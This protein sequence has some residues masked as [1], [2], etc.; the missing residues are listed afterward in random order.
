MVT[1]AE[2]AAAAPQLA[3]DGHELLYARGDGEALLATVREGE[4]PRIHPINVAVVE[5][6]LYAFLLPSA[7]R[8]DLEVDG[9]FALHSH[10]DP[11]A[12]SEFEVR[13]RARI[14][15]EPLRS[16]IAAG[17]Y[18]AIDDSY[19]LFQLMIASALLGRRPTADDWP[20]QYTSWRPAGMG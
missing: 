8:R 13:G 19:E 17:W 7:K 6:G 3:A 1:W 2:F 9:R 4:P 20:P 18:F 5:G 12:P 10:Q 15:G 11:A 14:V 16:T